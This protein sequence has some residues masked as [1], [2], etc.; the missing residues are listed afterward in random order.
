MDEI[1]DLFGDPVPSNWGGRGRPQHI[2]TQQNRNRV[3]MLVALGW[4]NE[5][6]AAALYV[7]QPT[8][9]K[10]YF[11]ELRFRE[12][13]RDRLEA[14]VAMKLWE[15]V[16]SGSVSAIRAFRDFVDRNDLMLYGHTA[17]PAES[18]AMPAKPAKLGKKEAAALAAQNPDRGSVLGDLVAR[19]QGLPN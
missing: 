19:R 9:R 4:S 1:F 3:S 2:P 12:V 18:A 13:A 6:I 16:Q 14:G 7:T 5:R 17:K 10:H 11:S 8:L 15:G